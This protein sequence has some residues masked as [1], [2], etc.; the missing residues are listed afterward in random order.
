MVI[1]LMVDQVG[2]CLPDVLGQ[3]VGHNRKDVE[4]Y[5]FFLQ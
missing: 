5:A 2:V 3:F 1:D 4:L